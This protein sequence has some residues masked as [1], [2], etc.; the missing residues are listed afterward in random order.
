V[1]VNFGK[2]NR[3]KESDDLLF[4]PTC[5]KK[6]KMKETTAQALK[7]KSNTGDIA[8]EKLLMF[9][10]TG[11]CHS[12]DDNACRPGNLFSSLRPHRN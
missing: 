4:F 7:Q 12:V 9:R 5:L 1:V 2:G 8:E 10:L 6:Y 11:K 3:R